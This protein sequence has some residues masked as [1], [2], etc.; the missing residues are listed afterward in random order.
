MKRKLNINGMSCMHCVKRV[1]NALK[2]I[3]GVT[4]AAVDLE[5]KSAVVTSE[6]EVSDQVLKDT[7]E[8]AG[9]DVTKIEPIA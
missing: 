3:D 9:Y 8:D 5:G 4:E 1:Q 6:K 7:V 2:E